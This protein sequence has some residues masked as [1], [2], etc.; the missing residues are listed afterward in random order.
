MRKATVPV[1]APAVLA[2]LD[3]VVALASALWPRQPRRQLRAHMRATLAGRPRSTL[4]L[5]VLLARR[6]GRAIGFV[7]VGLRSHAEDCDARWPV[8][9]IEGWLVIESQRGRGVGRAL[10]RAAARW[11]RAR[12]C[13]ELASNAEADNQISRRAHAALGFEVLE[14]L[15]GF[16]RRLGRGR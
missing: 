3:D 5:A 14:A 7:E 4:P 9:F 8:G 15:V 10:I 2:D 16:R 11:S 12:G 6:A 13:R 1:V